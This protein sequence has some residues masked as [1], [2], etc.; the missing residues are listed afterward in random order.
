MVVHQAESGAR[1][2]ACCC[3]NAWMNRRVGLAP[4]EA[5]F[6][7]PMVLLH[8][9]GAT[10]GAAGGSCLVRTQGRSGAPT[11]GVVCTDEQ[12]CEVR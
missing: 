2:S 11:F 1:L 10:N 3:C 9:R 7:S 6:V 8:P 5:H 12:F 4:S